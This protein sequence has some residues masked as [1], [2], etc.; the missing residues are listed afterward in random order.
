MDVPLLPGIHGADGAELVRCENGSRHPV[1]GHAEAAHCLGAEVD[2][3]LVPP[4]PPTPAPG[5][6]QPRHTTRP[7]P[8]EL[9]PH[10]LNH[11]CGTRPLRS[12][13]PGRGTVL[14]AVPGSLTGARRVPAFRRVRA[15]RAGG[16]G[17]GRGSG[18]RFGRSWSRSR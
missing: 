7:Q 9:L 16:R 10:H 15:V 6:P 4:A 2:Q 5:S 18:G 8:M 14:S 11:R 3:A 1:S 13:D 12:S 17:E